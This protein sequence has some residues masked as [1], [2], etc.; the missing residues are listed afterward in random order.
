LPHRSARTIACRS[1][2]SRPTPCISGHEHAY[3]DTATACADE[4]PD[5][6]RVGNEIG[7]CDID[8]ALG[9]EE[10]RCWPCPKNDEYLMHN[11]KTL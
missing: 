9:C 2:W 7:S 1:W 6:E 4:F 10:R 5:H 8:R 11:Y 3:A